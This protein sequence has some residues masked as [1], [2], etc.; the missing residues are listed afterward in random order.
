M[1]EHP[2]ILC[3]LCLKNKVPKNTNDLVITNICRFIFCGQLMLIQTHMSKVRKKQGHGNKHNQNAAKNLVKSCGWSHIQKHLQH[4]EL[5]KVKLMLVEM[6]F[7]EIWGQASVLF[8]CQKKSGI[9]EIYKKWQPHWN[10]IHTIPYIP[11]KHHISHIFKKNVKHGIWYTIETNV[12]K[13]LYMTPWIQ[14]CSPHERIEFC[15]P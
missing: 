14:S 11:L 2:K 4:Y 9:L 7:V 5:E 1:G 8:V 6:I 10:T 12:T 3:R 13:T 15:K